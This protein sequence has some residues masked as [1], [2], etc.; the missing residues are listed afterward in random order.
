MTPLLWRATEIAY[1]FALTDDQADQPGRT[2]Q[3]N[4]QQQ[5]AEDDR[6]NVLI[7]VRQPEA[8]SLDHDGADHRPD[9]GSGTSEQDIKHDLRGHHHAEH[10]RP[11][12]ALMKRIKA[13]GCLLYTSDAADD[14]L[15]VDLGGRR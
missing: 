2:K 15:C 6:P 9:Q 8:D 3:N 5:H 10:V 11:D 7:A 14:L 12:E 1:T 4:Q 13:A